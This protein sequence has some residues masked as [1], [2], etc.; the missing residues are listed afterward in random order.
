MNTKVELDYN[1]QIINTLLFE[2]IEYID[3]LEY[4]D[5]NEKEY[6]TSDTLVLNTKK[7]A[8]SSIQYLEELRKDSLKEFYFFPVQDTTLFD[9]CH[10]IYDIV[11][12]NNL[13]KLIIS[14]DLMAYDRIDID[15]IDPI[16]KKG[17]KIIYYK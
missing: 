12:D 6:Y 9:L 10:S 3:S 2:Y 4:I 14:N 7:S 13:D 17:T 5:S 1:I 16:I 11:D 8:D 15:P